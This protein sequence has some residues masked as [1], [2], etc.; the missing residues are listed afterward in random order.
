MRHIRDCFNTKYSQIFIQAQRLDEFSKTIKKYLPEPF[1]PHCRVK[2]FQNGCL[3]IGT[4]DAA[5]A[6]QLRYLL[7]ELR[8]HLRSQEKWY[9]LISIKIAIDLEAPIVSSSNQIKN[10][11]NPSPWKKI[12]QSLDSAK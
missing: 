7:P 12:L 5:W 9:Q 1:H 4:T 10:S 8:D 2:G 6:S 3:V 11:E